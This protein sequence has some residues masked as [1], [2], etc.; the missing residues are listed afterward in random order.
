[1]SDDTIEEDIHPE[2]KS[3]KGF[4]PVW[5]IPVV[6]LLLGLWLVKRNYDKKGEVIMVRF[7]NAADLAAGKTEVKCRNVTIGK[8]EDI[9]LTDEL[10]VDVVL[11]IKPDHLHLVREGSQF[12]VVRARVQGSSVS[13]LGTLISGA[14]IELDPGL[15][16]GEGV[17][18]KSFTGLE[19]PPLTPA[20]VP[21]LRLV[22]ESTKPGSVDIGSGIYYHDTLVGKV[23]SRDF[24]PGEKVVRFGVFIEERYTEL[25][26]D[27]TLFWKTSGVKLDV[28][29][30]GFNL[31]LP[32]LDSLVSGRISV[33]E[34]DDGTDDAPLEDGALVTLYDTEEL[35]ETSRFRGGTEFLLL[36]DKSLKGLKRGAAVEFRGLRIGRVSDISYALVEEPKI[37][38]M[39]VL[40]Q[41]DTRLLKRHFPESLVDMEAG[42]FTEQISTKLQA[43]ISSSNFITGQMIVEL[44][45]YPDYLSSEP[46]TRN[47]YTVLP[48]IE[49]GLG[50]LE[51]GVATLLEKINN[52]GL[53]ELIANLAETS[54]QATNALAGIEAAIADDEGVVVEAR[55]ALASLNVILEDE[56][57]RALPADLRGTLASLNKTLEPLSQDGAIYGDLRR[58]LDEL[59]GTAR[60]IDRL[61]GEIADKPN[62]LLFGKDGNTSKIPRGR[63]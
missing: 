42:N 26:S 15:A 58:T 44:N 32:S 20:S 37:N 35:A 45:Y 22:L 39:P 43:T 34:P 47:G 61:T 29:A 31:E 51:E 50:K 54:D 53:E 3:S 41:L 9:S 21:G 48:V 18:K 7:E 27:Q 11:R 8:V 60:S 59:R 2:V 14:Y 33:D 49:S 24:L 28:G 55:D 56:G 4:N 17:R 36:I 16:E 40:I 38:E 23:E 12:W 13:G 46:V 62:S 57:T 6:A 19:A 10:D 30:G 52:L 63:R 25:I 5:I 1:M